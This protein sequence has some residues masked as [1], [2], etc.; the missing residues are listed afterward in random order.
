MNFNYIKFY[1]TLIALLVYELAMLLFGFDGVSLFK[2]IITGLVWLSF[3]VAFFE[4]F[5]FY[6]KFKNS[7]PYFAYVVLTILLS[8]NVINVLRSVIFRDG[9]ITTILGNVSA[10][11]AILVPFTII[12]SYRLGN[13]RLLRK[14][15]FTILQIGIVFFFFFIA[16]YGTGMSSPQLR[17]LLVLLLPVMFLIPILPFETIK[18]KFLVVLCVV[19]YIYVS[20]LFGNRTNMIRSLLLILSL[21]AIFLYYKFQLKWVLT[22]SCFALLIPVFLLQQSYATGDSAFE[23]YL[24]GDADDDLNTD[25]RT[26]LY[27]ELFDDLI[28]NNRVLIGKGGNGTYYSAYFNEADINET[29]QRN[30]IEVGILGILLKGGMVAVILNLLVLISAIY[31]AFFKSKNIYNVGLGFILLIH[32]ILLFVENYTIYSSYNIFIWVVIGFCLSKP[33]GSLTNR[34]V[35]IVLNPNN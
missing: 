27:T 29:D 28:T 26:F 19:L 9:T 7:I 4:Y 13:L 23:T 1:I 15:Y 34:Q 8:W 17:A 5:K 33:M 3:G 2:L 10:A 12:F 25:T 14:Y 22:L 30:N 20:I 16:L 21:C 31:N 18:N 24:S 6:H 11:L 32:T 35:Y